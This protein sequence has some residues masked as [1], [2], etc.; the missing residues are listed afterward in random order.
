MIIVDSVEVLCNS[1]EVP[2]TCSSFEVLC[3]SFVVSSL[4]Q[5]WGSFSTSVASLHFF[6][7]IFT[8]VQYYTTHPSTSRGKPDT[9][10][11]EEFLESLPY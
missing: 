2:C 1:F 10:V 9:D 5:F 3:D 7:W 11:W 6:F 4:W 8:V